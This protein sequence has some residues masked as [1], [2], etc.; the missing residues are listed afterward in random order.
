[1]K[2]KAHRLQLIADIYAY[3]SWD[4]PVY[5]G[6]DARG[7]NLARENPIAWD[8]AQIFGAIALD[9]KVQLGPG[10]GGVVH[11]RKNKELWKRISEFVDLKVGP[12][13][14]PG[15]DK[16]AHARAEY[17]YRNGGR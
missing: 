14:L 11:L 15:D 6:R 5:Y 13:K 9:C 12:A 1:M 17:L 2:S 7:Y 8:M 4:A 10:Y 16:S 3:V